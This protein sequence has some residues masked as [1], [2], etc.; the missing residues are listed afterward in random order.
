VGG[1]VAGGAVGKFLESSLT[2][3]L[4][5][6]EIFFYEDALRQGRSVLVGLAEDDDRMNAAV[7]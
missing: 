1:A 4:P 3:G 6:D 7:S 5:K 2:Q